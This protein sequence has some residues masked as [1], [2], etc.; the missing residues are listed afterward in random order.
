MNV[1]FNDTYISDNPLAILKPDKE[2]RRYK[3]AEFLHREERSQELHEYYDG[4]ITKLPMARSPHN[5]IGANMIFALKTG[6]KS[7]GKKYLVSGLQQMVYLPKLNFGL[8]PDVL[9]IAEKP[10]F[11]DSNEVLLTN[12]IVIVEV[13]SRGTGKYDRNEKFVEYRTLP[14]FKEYILID[15]KKCHVEVRT[16]EGP[17]FW[18]STF[19][20]D[21]SQPLY[22]KSL[23]CTLDL[24]DI[25]ENIVFP[26]PKSKTKM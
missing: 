15:Q 14:S 23:D 11:W 6:F 13:L 21:S 9:V 1:M 25:Y 24:N 16:K 17:N 7:K 18:Q 20:T 3:L 10:E 8:Y 19:L 4:I 5:L 22:L 26:T 12:P 2:P